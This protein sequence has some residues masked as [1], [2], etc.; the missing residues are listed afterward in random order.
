MMKNIA[1]IAI[2]L[3]PAPA[4][5]AEVVQLRHVASIYTDAAGN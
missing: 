2:L 5:S 3:L 1:L 4:M